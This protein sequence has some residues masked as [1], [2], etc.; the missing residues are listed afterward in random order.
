MNNFLRSLPQT[1][2]WR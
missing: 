2:I 1:A